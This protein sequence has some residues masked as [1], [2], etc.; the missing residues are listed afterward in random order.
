MY[1]ADTFKKKKVSFYE[2]W[3]RV[4]MRIVHVCS[5]R[6]KGKHLSLT[7]VGEQAVRL[8][9]LALKRHDELQA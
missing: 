5:T 8:Q 4:D 1:N 7:G 2:R 3:T 6:M 9:Y